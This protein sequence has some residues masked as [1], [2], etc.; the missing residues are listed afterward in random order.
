[1]RSPL[2]LRRAEHEDAE[3][4]VELWEGVM[5]KASREDQVADARR[6]IADCASSSECCIVVAEVDGVV[7]GS[8]YLCATTVT[9][10]NLEPVVQAVHPHVAP[11]FQGRG[12]GKALIEAAVTYAEDRGIAHVASAAMAGSRDANRFMARLALAPLATLRLAP[13]SAVRAKLAALQPH[14]GRPQPA[15]HPGAGRPPLAAAQPRRDARPG[16]RLSAVSR[17]GRPAR[18]RR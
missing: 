2:T 17:P 13:T 7:A 1:M 12:V 8:V 15:P 4:L 5:R 18:A 11:R 14:R 9:P 6:I 10:V 16:R 3:A